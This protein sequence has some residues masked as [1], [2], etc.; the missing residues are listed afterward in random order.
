MFQ[1]PTTFR[2]IIIRNRYHSFFYTTKKSS[3][4]ASASPGGRSAGKRTHNSVELFTVYEK[5][6]L[7]IS[8]RPPE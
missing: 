2:L 5:E 1:V 4:S 7:L 6:K 8:C 3:P